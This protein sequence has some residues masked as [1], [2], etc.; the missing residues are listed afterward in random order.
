MRQD[1]T[2]RILRKSIKI[3]GSNSTST[4][5]EKKKKLISYI[6][7]ANFDCMFKIYNDTHTVNNVIKIST[8]NGEPK[9]KQ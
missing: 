5:K 6:T 3:T 4:N 1:A 2:F 7:D 9:Q 8:C